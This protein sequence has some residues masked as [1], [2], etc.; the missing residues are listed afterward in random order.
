MTWMI[1]GAYGYTGELV[2]NHARSQGLQPVLAGRNEKKL[3]EIANRLELDYQVVNLDDTVALRQALGEMELVVHCAGPFEVTAAPMIDAC[4][5]TRTHYL[6]ITGEV[7]VFE[8]A[9]DKAEEAERAGIVVCPGVGF[10]VI[11]TDCVAAQ[12]KQQLPDANHLTLGFDSASR[13]SRGTAKTS[14]RRLGEGGAVR[15][16]GNIEAVPLAY[17]TR[18]IDFGNGE[19]FAMTIPWGDVSTAYYTTGIPSIEVFIPASPN[20]V[21]RLKR[22]NAWRWLL[23]FEWVKKWLEKKVDQ[24][25]AGPNEK[26]LEQAVTYVWG[27]ASNAQGKVVTVREKVMNGYKLTSHGAV[28]IA[29]YV[30]AEKPKGGYY[31]PANLCGAELI[32]RY[33][34]E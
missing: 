1:Y 25:P 2:A 12:L 10:D 7:A 31:T 19:K 4:I 8:Y 5:A 13:M 23:R 15:R 22:M 34:V 17:R 24:Q 20:L 30:I 6:D 11:P 3:Q 26:Q 21:K 32:E 14:V 9:H 16:D 29:Q 28:D 18:T 27:E 33:R